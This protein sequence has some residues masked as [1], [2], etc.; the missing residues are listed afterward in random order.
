M[1]LKYSCALRASLVAQM[2]RNL[3]A[4]QETKFSPWI[5][6][7]PWKRKWQL[8]PVCHL[9]IFYFLIFLKSFKLK[10]F[11]ITV[12][13]LIFCLDG[14]FIDKKIIRLFFIIVNFPFI[15]AVFALYIYVLLYWVHIC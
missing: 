4:M 2:V 11:K 14:L 3:L 6:K 1:H 10:S 7:I 12:A 15:P 5:G 8:T 9:D 13:V